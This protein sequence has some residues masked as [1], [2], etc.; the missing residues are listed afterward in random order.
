MLKMKFAHQPLFSFYSRIGNDEQ[1]S[2]DR[3][4]PQR[5]AA[6]TLGYS[7]LWALCQEIQPLWQGQGNFF[8]LQEKKK[9]TPPFLFIHHVPN[10]NNATSALSIT[11]SI[12]RKSVFMSQVDLPVENSVALGVSTV[13][14]V[15]FYLLALPL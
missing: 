14:G 11:A 9:I 2:A 10:R 5:A 8:Y 3:Q 6:K 4:G 7:V 13:R 12:A 1:Q 15:G